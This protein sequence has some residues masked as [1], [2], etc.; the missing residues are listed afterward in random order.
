VVLRGKVGLHLATLVGR[1]PV[2]HEN[3]LLAAEVSLEVSEKPD[4]ALGVVAART[5]LKEQPRAAAVVAVGDGRGDRQLRPIERVNQDGRFPSGCPG[6]A[7][8]RAL[9]DSAFVLKADPRLPA[10]SVF[11]TS[12]Q[13][14]S[15]QCWTASGFRSRACRAGRWSV[16][17]IAPRIRHTWPG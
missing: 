7:D 16:Q 6:P 2:P 15:T 8:R 3:G 12:G 14:C 13:R 11:F 9:R 1:Q 17:S 4:E 5:G 10:A